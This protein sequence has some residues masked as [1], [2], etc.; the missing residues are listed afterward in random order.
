MSLASKIIET[1][2]P[3]WAIVDKLTGSYMPH[4]YGI[5]RALA[6]SSSPERGRV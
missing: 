1:A 2:S 5:N 4:E 6:T 3:I